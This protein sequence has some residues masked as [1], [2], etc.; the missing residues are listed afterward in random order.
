M[1]QLLDLEF[2]AT[3]AKHP[4][5]RD[6]AQHLGITAPAVSKRLIA[7]ERRLGVRLMNRTTRRVSLTPEGEIYLLEGAQ[8]LESL[9]ALER[10][11]TGARALPRGT[12]RVVATLG[13]GR[14]YVSPALSAFARSFPEVEV[15]LTLTDRPV[16]LIEQGFDLQIRLGDLPDSSLTA[17][18]LARNRRVLGAAQAYIAKHGQPATPRELAQ[19]ACLFIQENSET[20]GTWHLRSGTHAETVKVRGPLASNDGE[21]VVNWALDGHGVLMRSLWEIAPLLRSGRLV[22]VLPKWDLPSADIYAVFPTRNYLSAK[23]RA[24]VDFLLDAFE[25]HRQDR[26]GRW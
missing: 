17:R 19:H 14:R 23:T 18:L 5:L 20:F 26:D 11:V 21:C 13:F 6:A 8:V 7:L 4:S 16:N 15:Q 3:L 1:S 25:E 9:E 2:F 22:P 12:L 10:K 24:L